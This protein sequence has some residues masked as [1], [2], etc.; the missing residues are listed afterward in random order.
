MNPTPVNPTALRI[1]LVVLLLA[2]FAI[3]HALGG[4]IAIRGARPNLALTA[5]LVSGLFVDAAT[6][7]WMGAMVGLLE[8]AYLDRYVGSV[9]VSR[10]IPG[11]ALGALEERIFRDH[12][13]IAI[14]AAVAGTFV[15]EGLF[16][17]FAPQPHALR[18]LIRT[19]S[20][21]LYNG[22]LAIPVYLV[23]H[24]LA[25]QNA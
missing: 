1:R 13:L 18:W 11:F 10:I 15:T 25:K 3:H 14:A 5:L 12:V 2:A 22:V 19:A 17:L 9:I 6:G 4:D 24:R 8:A 16:Y 21:S 7:A 23:I 20:S